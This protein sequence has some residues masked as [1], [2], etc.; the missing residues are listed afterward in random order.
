M[1]Y[2]ATIQVAHESRPCRRSRSW[3]WLAALFL[4][5]VAAGCGAPSR[6]GDDIPIDAGATPGGDE[7]C[8]PGFA[9]AP[10]SLGCECL[11]DD[12]CNGDLR[13][14]VGFCEMCPAGQEGCGCQ[15]DGACD[16]DLACMSG[17]C[18]PE[19]CTDGALDCPCRDMESQ[20]RCDGDAYCASSGLCAVC[21]SDAAGCPCTLGACG[22]G[23]ACGEDDRCRAPLTCADLR[24]DGRCGQHEQCEEGASGADAQCLMGQCEAGYHW[25]EPAGGLAGGCAPDA[26]CIPGVPG[27]IARACAAAH[28]TCVDEPTGDD[29]CGECLPNARLEDG[30]C[31]PEIDCGGALC[32]GEQY[33]DRLAEDG[34]VCVDWPCDQ[35][36]QAVNSAGACATCSGSCDDIPGST[37]RFWPFT[38]RDDSCVCETRPGH[39]ISTSGE[40]N[41]PRQCDADNDTWV[42]DEIRHLNITGPNADPALEQN[43]RCDVRTVDRVVLMDEYGISVT[44]HSCAEGMVKSVAQE[45]DPLLCDPDGRVPLRLLEGERNDVPG[46]S[47]GDPDTPA[48]GGAGGRHLRADELNG[49]T[50]ACVSSDGDF[51]GNG[52]EDIDEVQD[53]R[54][55]TSTLG[56]ESRLRSFAYFLELYTA[57]YEPNQAGPYGRLVVAERSR[58]DGSYFPLVYDEGD[59][60]RAYSAD[61]PASYWRSCARK[62]DPGFDAEGG[63]AG[64]DFAQWGCDA[65]R[66]SCSTAPPAHPSVDGGD[67]LDPDQV[68]LRGHG[69][70][71]LGDGQTPVDGRWRGMNHH[72]QFRCVAVVE[73][74]PGLPRQAATPADFVGSSGSAPTLAMNDCHAVRCDESDCL[75]SRDGGG[76]G[77]NDPVVHCTARAEAPQVGEVGWAAVAYQPYGH[78]D[79]DGQADDEVYAGS[80]VN[81]DAEWSYVC[82][83]PEFGRLRDAPTDAFGRYR[84]H[85]WESFFLWADAAETDLDH[86]RASLLWASPGQ[87][88]ANGSVWR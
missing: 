61:S 68:L 73:N 62:R 51:N 65:R 18:M 14:V 23:L 39:F 36:D 58:C 42:R 32:S 52:V 63:R 12:S 70:C 1:K 59:E 44:I 16:G 57:R 66:E 15:G 13:C 88:A 29:V 9:G 55:D 21:S 5:L 2:Q 56:E 79:P 41:R 17:L 85:G 54:A 67:E 20:A 46:R 50:K 87:E 34:P 22:G 53:T 82:P 78:V 84:C 69:L 71:E 80:C 3:L 38:A 33:C 11:A 10:G 77:S 30:Q 6:A 37:G 8:I 26:S 43:M 60:Q 72:S 75:E 81:E 76:A 24:A 31:V 74:N 45:V 19:S 49:L 35:A 7:Q 28:R 83:V 48:Y 25:D 27:S 86:D 47:T 64:Y 40:D 4:V